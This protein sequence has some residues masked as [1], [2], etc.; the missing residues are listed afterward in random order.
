LLGIAV[1]IQF[2]LALINFKNYSKS[3]KA[4]KAL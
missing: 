4:D 2:L 3:I 1:E